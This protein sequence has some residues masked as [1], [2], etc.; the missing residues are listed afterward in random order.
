MEEIPLSS[1]SLA[2]EKQWKNQKFPLAISE[3]RAIILRQSFPRPLD[4]VA[5]IEGCDG[6]IH[7]K[8]GPNKSEPELRW[9][10]WNRVSIRTTLTAPSLVHAATSSRLVPPNPR[11]TSKFALSAIPSTLVSRSW[12]TLA[13][14][15][16]ASTSASAVS[17]Y[18]SF[19]SV[20]S[21]GKRR[22]L[23]CAAS[24]F[25]AWC[26]FVRFT[27]VCLIFNTFAN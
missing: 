24:F 3:I 21:C 13:D 1:L 15:L 10:E 12:L 8:Y 16:S 27:R 11:S 22:F 5:D 14:V 17:N 2:A 4:G 7:Y 9:K 18:W 25:A 26:R 19:L 23:F 20:V 6:H